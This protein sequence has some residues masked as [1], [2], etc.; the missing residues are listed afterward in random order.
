MISERKLRRF[1]FAQR[2]EA[3][4]F[5]CPLPTAQGGV[6]LVLPARK[7]K[8]KKAAAAPYP[9][10]S[11][12]CSGRSTGALPTLKARRRSAKVE[13]P[14]SKTASKKF[15]RVQAK[16][17]KA[18]GRDALLETLAQHALQPK[19][20]ELLSSMKGNHMMHVRWC[21]RARCSVG[22]RS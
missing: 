20:Q 7:E 1:G 6:P 19:T 18:K 15:A 22:L 16:I 17:E 13:A 5:D 21:A 9:A 14:L 4:V 11:G 3:P 2:N 8:G 10:T 12:L